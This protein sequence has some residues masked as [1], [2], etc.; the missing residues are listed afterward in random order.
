M[1]E[2]PRTPHHDGRCECELNPHRGGHGQIPIHLQQ[3]QVTAHLQHYNGCCEDGAD[4]EPPS[5]ILELRTRALCLRNALRLE[6]HSADRTIA[7]LAFAEFVDASDRCRSCPEQAVRSEHS[8]C[9]RRLSSGR[10][11]ILTGICHEFGLATAATKVVGL[12]I[13]LRAVLGGRWVH[14]HAADGI[15]GLTRRAF[16]AA[17]CIRIVGGRSATTRLLSGRLHGHTRSLY[18]IH[19]VS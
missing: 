8:A 11:Q 3:P 19:G 13:V 14:H 5:H 18:L 17:T 15:M 4:H 7:G 2:G 9:R 12:A 6:R 10:L 16:G 1:E